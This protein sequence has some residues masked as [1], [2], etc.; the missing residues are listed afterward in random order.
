MRA[1]SAT[2]G[3]MLVLKHLSG[4]GDVIERSI[5]VTMKGML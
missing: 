3:G 4:E 1:L 5:R 2:L